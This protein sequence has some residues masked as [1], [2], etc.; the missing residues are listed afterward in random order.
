M[1]IKIEKIS[2]AARGRMKKSAAIVLLLAMYIL[3]QSG[4]GIR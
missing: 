4:D 1:S 3:L 2:G